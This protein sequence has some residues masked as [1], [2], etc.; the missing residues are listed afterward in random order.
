MICIPS[1]SLQEFEKKSTSKKLKKLHS[2]KRKLEKIFA[3]EKSAVINA[4]EENLDRTAY[5]KKQKK[6]RKDKN[7][8]KNKKKRL[9]VD[10]IDTLQNNNKTTEIKLKKCR[11][12][13]TDHSQKNVS[14]CKISKDVPSK[15]LNKKIKLREKLKAVIQDEP[16]QTTTKKG[17]K[18]K[19]LS[20]KEKM[21]NKLKAAKFRLLNEQI[22]T[23]TGKK[24][25]DYFTNNTEDFLA[26]HE[27]YKQQVSKWPLNPL[28]VIIKRINKLCVFWFV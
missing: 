23:T 8:L 20:V 24:M 6:R 3:H 22:Y 15:L 5:L 21:V 7:R 19:L 28:D 4:V 18:S 2:E 11:S 12:E 27:G 14:H 1:I 9:I 25:H 17:K 16:I 10:E 26:Y 13:H